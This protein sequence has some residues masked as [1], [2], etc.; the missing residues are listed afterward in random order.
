[1]EVPRPLH[2]FWL[3]VKETFNHWLDDD[4]STHAAALAYYTIFSIAPTLIIAV[5]IAG[6]IF[7]D[8][9]ARGEIRGQISGFVGV[10]GAT[11][12]EDMM[13]NAAKPGASMLASALGLLVLLFAATGVFAALQNALNAI[14]GA[15]KRKV[16]GIISFFHTRL[17]SLAMVLGVGFLLLVSLVISAGISAL[18]DWI[19]WGLTG[20]GWQTINFVVSFGFVTML[21]SMI[22]KV[23]PDVKVAWGDVWLGAAV[24]AVLFNIGKAVIGLYLGGGGVASSYGATG[25]LAVLLIWVYYSALVLF[26][27]AEFTHVY[28]QLRGSHFGEVTVPASAPKNIAVAPATVVGPNVTST[29]SPAFNCARSTSA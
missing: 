1:M 26:L 9:A 27:G 17:L 28:S 5:A 11:V 10:A 21:F 7:G 24:T 29:V 12:I 13:T 2:H 16:H 20:W 18:G 25:S 14:W 22:Y 19:G 8:E 15:P 4:I 6:A 3:I 23:L